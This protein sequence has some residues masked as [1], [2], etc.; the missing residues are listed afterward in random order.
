M[1]IVQLPS[2][3]LSR[4]TNVSNKYPTVVIYSLVKKKKKKKKKS[5]SG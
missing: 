3:E 2:G 4:P 1:K 5:N